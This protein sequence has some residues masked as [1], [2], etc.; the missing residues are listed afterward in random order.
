MAHDGVAGPSQAPTSWRG[1]SA[2]ELRVIVVSDGQ[3]G[4]V[5]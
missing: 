1:W 3:V 4:D 2:E 5:R